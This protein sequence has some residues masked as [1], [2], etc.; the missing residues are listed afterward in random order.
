M[1][2]T[3]FKSWVLFDVIA[4][5]TTVESLFPTKPTIP[6]LSYGPMPLM[7]ERIASL[8]LSARLFDVMEELSSTT[9]TTEIPMTALMPVTCV[10]IGVPSWVRIRSFGSSP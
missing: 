2:F 6:A 7:N 10:W 1:F 3:A 5:W 4:W 8:A 9:M